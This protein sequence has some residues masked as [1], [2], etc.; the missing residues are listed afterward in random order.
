[1]RRRIRLRIARAYWYED[2]ADHIDATAG[3]TASDTAEALG[4][5]R[6]DVVAAAA[7]VEQQLRDRAIRSVP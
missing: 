2:A 3:D 4:I 1:M 5:T 7:Q 6:A